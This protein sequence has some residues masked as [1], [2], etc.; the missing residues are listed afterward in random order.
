MRE[1][2]QVRRTGVAWTRNEIRM[3]TFGVAVPI[4]TEYGKVVGALSCGLGARANST[5]E[6]VKAMK[7]Q[8]RRIA[9][10]MQ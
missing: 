7:V 2:G 1:I 6:L 5:D 10:Q 4:V 8:A 3:N 9:Q